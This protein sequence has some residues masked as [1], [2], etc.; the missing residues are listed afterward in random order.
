M[1]ETDAQARLDE[2]LELHKAKKLDEAEAIYRELLE[3]LPQ[4]ALVHNLMGVLEGQRRNHKEAIR[5]L[6]DAIDINERVPDFHDNLGAALIAA[7]K[8][9]DAQQQ[10][11]RALELDPGRDSARMQLAFTL[12]PGGAYTDLIERLLRWRE[13][14]VYIEFGVRDGQTLALARKPTFAIGVQRK[15]VIRH[16]FEAETRVYDMTSLQ[17]L[18]SDRL[19]AFTGRKN[20]DI[21]LLRAPR[22]FESA[23]DLFAALEAVSTKDAI[24]VLNG[25]LP[26]DAV[27]GD[28]ERQSTFWVGDQWKLVPCLM[29]VRPELTIFTVP[30]YPAGLTFITGLRRRSKKLGKHRD[31]NIAAFTE[32]P[33]P[34]PEDWKKVFNLGSENWSAIRRR[35]GRATS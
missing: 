20:F 31:D 15:P 32:T 5:W 11:R 29:E 10:L 18:E 33:V 24:L 13:P 19:E 22:S 26:P 1:A 25:T 17:F 27:A 14:K 34:S 2:A 23:Y 7:G 9:E 12:L 16:R 8:T 28:P 6:R 3:A 30:V 4:S 21:A 35:L